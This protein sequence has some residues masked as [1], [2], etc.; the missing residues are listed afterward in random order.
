MSALP[1]PLGARVTAP[2]EPLAEAR[3]RFEREH[4]ERALAR[5]GGRPG[6]AA[7]TLGLTRQ[8]LAKTLRRLGLAGEGG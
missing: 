2:V 4:V 3:T 5:A 6:V 8:G 7:Q 1:S